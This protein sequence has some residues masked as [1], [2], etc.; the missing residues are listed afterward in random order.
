MAEAV[1]G[2]HGVDPGR[3]AA[4]R[5]DC[6]RLDEH[7]LRDAVEVMAADTRAGHREWR[8][9]AK[10]YAPPGNPLHRGA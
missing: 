6:A 1:A 10:R 2:V 5:S 3:L 9:S 8:R 4:A 7:W